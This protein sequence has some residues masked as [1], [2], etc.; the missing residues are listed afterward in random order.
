MRKA[1]IAATAL[2]SALV[3]AI[4][5]WRIEPFLP[6]PGGT[7]RFAANHDPPRAMEHPVQPSALISVSE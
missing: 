3:L 6:E 5:L 2:L 4:Y 1:A 7:T